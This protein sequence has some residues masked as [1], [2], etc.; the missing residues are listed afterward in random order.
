M[1]L[2]Q[3]DKDEF[4]HKHLRH[5]LTLLRTLTKRTGDNYNFVGQGD[6]YRCVKDSNLIAVRMFLNFFGLKGIFQ[7]ETFELAEQPSKHQDDILIDKF[8]GHLIKPD[9]I[10]KN[11][12]RILAGV[13]IRADKELAHITNKFNR[14]FNEKC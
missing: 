9:E 10:S 14:E 7:N 12:Q 5:R 4:L 1:D 13:Y 11:S 8:I 6:I 3:E 2:T